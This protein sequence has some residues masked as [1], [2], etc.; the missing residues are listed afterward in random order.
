MIK[1]IFPAKWSRPIFLALL[2]FIFNGCRSSDRIDWQNGRISR[3]AGTGEQGIYSFYDSFDDSKILNLIFSIINNRALLFRFCFI[4]D[5]KYLAG[6][7]PDQ[8]RDDSFDNCWMI[9]LFLRDS[10]FVSRIILC[11]FYIP[12]EQ[13]VVES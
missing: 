13:I 2:F 8:L 1:G 4:F 6:L 3:L 11:D 12:L 10:P 7:P 9:Y 5:K